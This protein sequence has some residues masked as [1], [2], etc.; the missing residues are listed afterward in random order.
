M[1]QFKS[2]KIAKSLYEFKTTDRTGIPR[3]PKTGI[4]ISKPVYVFDADFKRVKEYK[5][6]NECAKDLGRC[7]AYITWLAKSGNQYNGFYYSYSKNIF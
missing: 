1:I 7:S 3:N 5:S 6:G 2:N 4:K